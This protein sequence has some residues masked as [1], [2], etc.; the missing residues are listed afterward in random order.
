MFMRAKVLEV[1][2]FF[3]VLLAS[4][5]AAAQVGGD[6]SGAV[7]SQS[8]GA[9][10]RVFEANRGQY[11]QSDAPFVARLGASRVF[12]EKNALTFQLVELV[13]AP[14][15]TGDDAAVNGEADPRPGHARRIPSRVCNV[16]FVFE[17]TSPEAAVVG[18]WKLEGYLNYF[19]G[20]DPKQW[21]SYVPT[22][23]AARVTNVYPGIDLALSLPR[24][25]GFKYDVHVAPGADLG[26]FRV[27]VEGADAIRR[28]SP[29][30]LVIETPLGTMEHTIPAAWE[31]LDGGSRRDV[32]ASVVNVSEAGFGL[33]ASRHDG[34]AEMVVDPLVW[35]TF[36]GGSANDIARD[37]A[38]SS[39]ELANVTGGTGAGTG[40]PTTPG[41]YV[42]PASPN[43]HFF[44]TRISIDG[45][46]LIWSTIISGSSGDDSEVAVDGSDAV[47]VVGTASAGLP[48]TATSYDPTFNGG[49]NAFAT[50]LS[51]DGASLVWS[52][53]FGATDVRAKGVAV[54]TAGVTTIVG[55]VCC[56][57]T[58]PTTTGFGTSSNSSQAFVCRLSAD[59]ST[60][61][62]SF[63]LGG[64]GDDAAFA[65]ALATNGDAVVAGYTFSSDFPTTAG[66]AF[67][68][69]GGAPNPDAFVLRAAS[70]GSS[71][72][73]STYLGGSN[74]DYAFSVA[75]DPVGSITV[76]GQT[77]ST[78]F[79]VTVGALDGLLGGSQDAFVTRLASNGSALI[80]STYLGGASGL[81]GTSAQ[82]FANDVAVDAAGNVV[83][84]GVTTSSD[85]PTTSMAF[86][87]TIGVS[88]QGGDG[89]ITVLASNGF[90]L[91]DST[92]LGGTGDDN[93][94]GAALDASGGLVVVGATTSTDFPVTPGVF[95]PTYSGGSNDGFVARLVIPHPCAPPAPP[96][97]TG[98]GFTLW[99]TQP[100][101]PGTLTIENYYGPPGEYFVS[102]F[103]FD[104]MNGGPVAGQGW[105]GGLWIPFPDLLLQANPFIGLPFNGVLNASGYSWWN[106]L[107]CGLPAGLPTLYGVTTTFAPGT[108]YPNATTSVVAIQ[109]F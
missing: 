1:R 100:G 41:S 92:F 57:G 19:V 25:G 9:L 15:A 21:R 99:V 36:L 10:H 61:V 89:F 80:W 5:T 56:F 72:V 27:R 42:P 46:T 101:G 33:T 94:M 54:D 58:I 40:F 24:T 17:G 26:R 63:L 48:T 39:G 79:P 66:G 68:A 103:T 8:L 60:L 91:L 23:A 49:L 50:R 86:D 97:P 84:V 7:Q 4:A 28:T 34:A 51:P 18:E 67:P 12:V 73:W 2:V 22:Y 85:F 64:S 87:T 29:E 14:P 90:S 75:I 38:L 53:Y 31:V 108:Y 30:K 3:L 78:D 71:L 55:M 16:R 96:P 52:T 65:V 20:E 44:I 45:S 98:S 76:V 47:T 102:A 59:G 32:R 43:G 37:V 106:L 109:L 82:D 88:P 62:W 93:V 6:A 74:H 69:G 11:P 13:D 105:W 35:S 104:A 83:V 70:D 107:P 95:D 77:S 81:P